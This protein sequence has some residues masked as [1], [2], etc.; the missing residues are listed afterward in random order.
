MPST[1]CVIIR[2]AALEDGRQSIAGLAPEGLHRRKLCVLGG[3]YSLGYREALDACRRQ[4]RSRVSRLNQR[5]G[6][7]VALTEAP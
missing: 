5:C 1:I 2:R 4:G 6:L 3:A 7:A